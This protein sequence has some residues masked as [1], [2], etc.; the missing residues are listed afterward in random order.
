MHDEL[1]I[2]SNEFGF[3]RIVFSLLLAPLYPCLADAIGQTA[4]NMTTPST[5]IRF[6]PIALQHTLGISKH[7]HTHMP[8]PNVRHLHRK[9][10]TQN[11]ICGAL[12]L[13]ALATSVRWASAV[14]WEYLATWASEARRNVEALSRTATPNTYTHTHTC[15]GNA[16]HKHIAERNSTELCMKRRNI[17]ADGIESAYV[18]KVHSTVTHAGSIELWSVAIKTQKHRIEVEMKNGVHRIPFNSNG[19][20]NHIIS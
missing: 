5:H 17:S 14:Q 19:W 15:T 12:R 8:T 18:H 7:T 16:K 6:K 20:W 13:R 11:M 9:R 4:S 2:N 1:A 10:Y 3:V